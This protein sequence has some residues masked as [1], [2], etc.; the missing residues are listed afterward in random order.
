[1]YRKYLS[2]KIFIPKNN[3]NFI[4]DYHLF[5]IFIDRAKRDKLIKFLFA[6]NIP[7]TVNYRSIQKLKYYKTK[8]KNISCPISEDYGEKTLS[9]PFHLSLTEKQIK[10]ISN[11]VNSFLKI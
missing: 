7:V 4:R 9:L 1:M 8:Y 3:K 2:E 5:P 11:K 10:F 6:N